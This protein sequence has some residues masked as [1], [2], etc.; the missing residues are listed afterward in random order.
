MVNYG[1]TTQ[2]VD[3]T[4]VHSGYHRSHLQIYENH[5]S[6]L[7]LGTV[8]YTNPSSVLSSIKRF[9]SD[10]AKDYFNQN[11][12]VFFQKEGIIHESSCVN[13]LQQN[14]IA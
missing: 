13:T 7:F 1:P 14:G 3:H 10:N 4:L 2:V 9:L 6:D 11:L 12:S 8:C 5:I